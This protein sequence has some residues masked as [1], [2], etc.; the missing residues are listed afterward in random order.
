MPRYPM[1]CDTCRNGNKVDKY[2]KLWNVSMCAV[3]VQT[4]IDEN[5][6]HENEK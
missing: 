2:A 3:C 1:D 4:S 5:G 6:K